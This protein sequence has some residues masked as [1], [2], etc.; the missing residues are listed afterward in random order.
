MYM[1]TDCLASAAEYRP[2]GVFSSLLIVLKK[3][4]A[5]ALSRQ[6]LLRL[7][8]CLTAGHPSFSLSLNDA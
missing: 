5:Q 1:N 4:S 2:S 8:L 3:F 7:M 6:F